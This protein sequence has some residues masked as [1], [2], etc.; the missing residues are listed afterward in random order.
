MRLKRVVAMMAAAGIVPGATWAADDVAE[1]AT[2]V[3]S[4][5]KREI[6]VS[7]APANV[8]VV[9]DK[10]IARRKV[11]RIGDALNEVPS[12]YMRG[13]PNGDQSV[14]SGMG[15]L[16]LR[17]QSSASGRTMVMVDGVPMNSA[18]SGNVNWSGID[19]SDVARVEVVPGAFSSLYGSNAIGGVINVI[20]KRPEKEEFKANL[21]Y[22]WGN[23]ESVSGSLL[24][25]NKLDNGF[26]FTLSYSKTD[27]QGYPIDFVVK[28]ASGAP[29][30]A[31]VISGAQPT[32]KFT[33][34]T[35]TKD[36]SYGPAYILGDKGD[37]PWSEEN[38]ATK[39]F[40]DLGPGSYIYAGYAQSY[41]ITK[42]E[43]YHSYLTTVSGTPLNIPVASTNYN[44]NGAKLSLAES[45]FV[46]S[47]PSVDGSKIYTAG[48]EGRVGQD[49]VVKLDLSY[50]DREFW[51]DAGTSGK[52]SYSGGPGKH[53]A[54]PN[55]S[56]LLNAQL[57][58]ALSGNHYL[59]AGYA[60]KQDEA[61]KKQYGLS[62]W[63][64]EGSKTT[65]DYDAGGKT[66]THS[67][68]AQ[69]EIGLSEATTLYVGGRYDHWVT[70]GQAQQYAAG[71]TPFDT[72]Y[73]E[74][75]DSAFNPKVS[76]VNKP[77]PNS[78]LRASWGTSFRTPLVQELYAKAVSVSSGVTTTTET[79]P[80]LKPERA[81]S[82]E[83]G[84]EIQLANVL[85]K[86]TLFENNIRDLIYTKT[87]SAIPTAVL[88]QQ[89]N[90]GEARVRG[91]E[92]GA[93]W[94]LSTI[95]KLTSGLT[96][97]DSQMLKNDVDPLSVGSKLTFTPERMFNLA[98][99][100]EYQQ[101]AGRLSGRYVSHVYSDAHNRDTAEGLLGSYDSYTL[102]DAKLSYSIDK[103]TRIS[104]TAT[105]LLDKKYF[106]YYLMPGRNFQ[107][108]L[109]T[110]F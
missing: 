39:F 101:W 57:N 2:V 72:A 87:I 58:S 85:L 11:T 84:G 77:T 12:L 102:V 27:N 53:Y 41:S 95:W 78:T 66:T 46:S 70:S 63:R 65:L 92:L 35:T 37:R 14:G 19:L 45:D 38:F 90:A 9:S 22:S 49:S 26:G 94:R 93:V 82:W 34:S 24:Y 50:M 74:R 25:K 30:V 5:T 104:L 16:Y 64:Q 79:D 108:Q 100:G 75:Q 88:K 6:D 4:A 15:G 54:N 105:N 10:D 89:T 62:D 1:L 42:W 59:V 55:T 33:S 56:L 28:P 73:A 86:G 67:L 96:L 68:Y 106:A 103:S 61:S 43:P 44:L 107:L 17:G 40:Y 76:V 60:F 83:L 97:L 109:S 7:D 3:V 48:Y 8:T 110:G 71:G 69:D 23:A 80:N 29:G 20:T 36:G 98:L 21:G 81:S 99:E 47:T 13:S 18:Y 52:A 31:P 32:Q 51:Y 91:L